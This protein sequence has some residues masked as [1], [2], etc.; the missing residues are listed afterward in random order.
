M[1]TI[2]DYETLQYFV[3]G[4]EVNSITA[5]KLWKQRFE[6]LENVIESVCKLDTNLAEFIATKWSDIPEVTVTEAFA[7]K[8]IEIRR[9]YFQA[10][11]V[12]KLM[13]IVKEKK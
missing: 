12:E 4:V 13:E 2:L 10:V 1:S 3:E 9:L 5:L 11:G 7:E 8:N 6:T